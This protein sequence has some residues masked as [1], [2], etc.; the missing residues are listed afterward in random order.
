MRLLWTLALLA[1]TCHAQVNTAPLHPATYVHA[2]WAQTTGGQGGK[3]LRVTTL[4][5]DG[6]VRSSASPT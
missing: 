1:G 3:I 4:A 2:G 6:A 5:S